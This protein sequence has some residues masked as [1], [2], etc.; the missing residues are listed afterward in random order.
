M[1]KVRKRFT[2]TAV[3]APLIESLTS[4]VSLRTVQHGKPH[5]HPK[6]QIKRHSS[7]STR[8]EWRSKSCISATNPA[9]MLQTIRAY[10]LC[11]RLQN[12][13]RVPQ[14]RV[15]YI[16][17]FHF[18]LP[19]C[20][21]TVVLLNGTED[22]L[23]PEPMLPPKKYHLFHRNSFGFRVHDVDVIPRLQQKRDVGLPQCSV[24]H[25]GGLGD[26]IFCEVSQLLR[27]VMEETGGVFTWIVCGSQSEG[28]GWGLGSNSVSRISA[29]INDEFSGSFEGGLDRDDVRE[30]R[31]PH[32]TEKAYEEHI[33]NRASSDKSEEQ[34]HEVG[35]K[36]EEQARDRASSSKFEEEVH[37]FGTINVVGVR[38][39]SHNLTLRRI[40]GNRRKC[41]ATLRR[42][43]KAVEPNYGLGLVG[44]NLQMADECGLDSQSKKEESGSLASNNLDSLN[45]V[46]RSFSNRKPAKPKALLLGGRGF[47]NSL[48]SS[49]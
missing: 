49:K 34:I 8:T 25:M 26:T 12:R 7:T 5:D 39:E 16:L 40:H 9:Q 11:A 44:G 24:R 45:R 2:A 15:N 46:L 36:C 31:T 47:K 4:I 33:R 42:K 43:I 21:G 32:G 48:M 38:K 30:L 6:A 28:G 22:N 13:G 3:P 37:E 1:M 20:G 27:N 19:W 14:G 23:L 29:T 17:V 41:H 10:T 35:T 18:P